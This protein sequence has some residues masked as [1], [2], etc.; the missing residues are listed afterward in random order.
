MN[1]ISNQTTVCPPSCQLTWPAAESSARKVPVAFDRRAPTRETV[2]PIHQA[3]PL[4]LLTAESLHEKSFANEFAR[5]D[6]MRG[7]GINE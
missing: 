5:P 2:I 1:I 7:W 3:V 6:A 4:Q